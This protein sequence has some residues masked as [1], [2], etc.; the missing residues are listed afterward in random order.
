MADKKKDIRSVAIPA[1]EKVLQS[2]KMAEVLGTYRRDV[3]VNI[4]REEIAKL[5]RDVSKGREVEG[6]DPAGVAAKVAERLA[7]LDSTPPVPVVN[8]TGIILHTNL[9]RSILSANTRKALDAA[10]A[11]YCDLEI[12]LWTGERTRRDIRLEEIIKVLTGCE[13]AT[14]VNNNAAAVYLALNTIAEGCEVITSRGELIEIGGSFRIPDVVA[15]SG[16]K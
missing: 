2:D 8:A 16:H 15:K 6:S 14:V 12:N 3:V 1:V 13:A 11:S 9:G 7:Q 4:V 10:A 5:R